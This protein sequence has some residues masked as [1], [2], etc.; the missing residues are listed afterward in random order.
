MVC[1]FQMCWSMLG[2]TGAAEKSVSVRLRQ[3]AVL[4]SSGIAVGRLG[5]PLPDAISSCPDLQF[6]SRTSEL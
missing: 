4:Y 5:T 2:M 1:S 6:R 3:I